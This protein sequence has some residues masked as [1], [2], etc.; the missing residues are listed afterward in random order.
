MKARLVLCWLVASCAG[1]AHAWGPLGHRTVAETAALLVQDDLPATWGPLLARHRFALGVYA[2]VPDFRF[3][4]IDGHGGKL[5]APTHYLYLDAAEGTDR[6]S[7]DRRIAQFV[8]RAR[9]QL[10]PVRAPSGGYLAGAEATGDARRIYLGLIELGVMAHYSG[11]AAVPYHATADTNGYA[12]GEGGI[13]FYFENE[14]VDVFEPGLATDVLET[15]RARRAEWLSRWNAAKASPQELALAVLKESLATV[16]SV[17]EIDRRD[18][19]VK[20]EPSGS[21]GNAS[22]KPA[23]SGCRALR[24]IVV[25]RLAQGAVLTAVLWERALPTRG[26]DFQKARELSFSDMEPAPAFVPPSAP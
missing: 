1:A 9:T 22:R 24:P 18:A 2:F 20:L 3:R 17:S 6:G 25:L 13:H 4:H 11:D 15:A 26:V 12:R 5:E 14:C 7:V 21:K 10:G 19:V 16:P 8:E 23:S